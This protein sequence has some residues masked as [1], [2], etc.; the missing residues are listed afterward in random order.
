MH[1]FHLFYENLDLKKYF[2]IS[3]NLILV[4]YGLQW[5]LEKY[6]EKPV[7]YKKYLEALEPQIQNIFHI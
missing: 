3:E 2:K 7:R 5:N 1:T 4:K 6:I